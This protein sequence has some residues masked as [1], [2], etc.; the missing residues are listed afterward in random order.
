M[1][2]FP[3]GSEI[4]L[5]QLL[6]KELQGTLGPRTERIMHHIDSSCIGHHNSPSVISHNK[7]PCTFLLSLRVSSIQI[8]LQDVCSRRRP[9]RNSTLFL[10]CLL[11]CMKIIK[12][13]H[14]LYLV[15]YLLG[16]HNFVPDICLI[17]CVPPNPKKIN[18][19][20]I[21]YPLLE[22]EL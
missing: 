8:N 9:A 5:G 20:I 7:A 1:N 3:K 11:M 19:L 12:R 22:K 4:Y 16:G 2:R 15:H 13:F 18:S 14:S 17:S 6:H 10:I 21:F